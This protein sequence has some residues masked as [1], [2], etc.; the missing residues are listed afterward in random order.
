MDSELVDA[1]RAADPAALGSRIRAARLAAGLTQPELGGHDASVAYISRIEKGERR[2]GPQLLE[3]F[4]ERVGVSAERL[5]LGDDADAARAIE[6][7]LDLAELELA[8]GKVDTAL[9]RIE[10]IQCDPALARVPDGRIRT[11]YVRAAAYDA[12]GAPE[13]IGAYEALIDDDHLGP[14]ALKAAIALSRV[15]RERG[16]LDA[17]VESAQRGLAIASERALDDTE[18]AVRLSV[19]L[20]AALYESGQVDRSAE[21]CR[22]AVEHAE[23]LAS[24]SARAAAYWNTSVIEAEAGNTGAALHLAKKA[25]Q[26]LETVDSVRNVARLR[27]QLSTIMLRIDPP[28]L[29]DAR[30]HLERAAEELERSDASPADR[31]RNDLILAR[32]HLANG[33]PDLARDRAQNA[34]DQLDET[35]L[36]LVRAAAQTLLGQIAWTKKKRADAARH[37]QSAIATLTEIGNDREAA[38]LWFELGTLTDEAG[39]VTQ[40]RDA[41]RRAAASTGLKSR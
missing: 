24:P 34:L 30:Q 23:R 11:R 36:P 5:V 39:L 27:T 20:A 41:F 13:A 15:H 22:Q 37:Y 3:L 16:E 28:D 38:Q 4:A 32:W 1:L 9:Q 40:A 19:T 21:V 35:D 18:D 25:L 12:L 14:F 10:A 6:L 7:E 29:D 2:P 8:G 26:L 31:A 17:A 33:D